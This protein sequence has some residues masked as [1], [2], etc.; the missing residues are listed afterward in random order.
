M[1]TAYKVQHLPRDGNNK[2]CGYSITHSKELAQRYV[3]GMITSR[4][5]D[6]E[7][8]EVQVSERDFSV[9]EAVEATN[10]GNLICAGPECSVSAAVDYI[11][12][13]RDEVR[14]FV[15]DQGLL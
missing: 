1:K 15:N 13:T 3:E 10:G 5:Y 9:M 14:R 7:I 8:V 4:F 2:S 11:L 12:K 6:F